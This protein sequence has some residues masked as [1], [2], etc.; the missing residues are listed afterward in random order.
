MNKLNIT[1]KNIAV[2]F[3]NIIAK[4]ISKGAIILLYGDLGVGKT[5]LSSEI[6]N[7]LM[8]RNIIV[9]SPTFQLLN[10][11]D[12]EKYNIY[13]YDL[14]RLKHLEEIYELGI[15]DALNGENIAIIE[16]P[17]IIESILPNDVWRVK[18]SFNNNMERIV[19][20]NFNIL[21]T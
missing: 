18:I 15:E 17:E 1:D 9:T 11:Y 8:Q 2:K 7:L 20:T 21:V 6:I 19:E 14:Y 12:A 3:A 16:W 5:F 13:H 10:I 4:Q